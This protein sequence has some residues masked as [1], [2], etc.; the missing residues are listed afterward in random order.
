MS[1][2]LSPRPAPWQHRG[3]TATGVGGAGLRYD[4]PQ[5]RWVL[6]AT[7]LGSGM[8]FLDGTVV[9]VALP[10]IGD[11]LD[12]DIAGLQWTI[13]AYTLTLASFILLGGS[14][15]DRWGRRRM[16]VLGTIGFAAASLL[17]GIAPNI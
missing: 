5:G 3:V 13:N 4:E 16:F 1:R 7:V 10:S 17:C 6:L 14:A 11:S 2:S 15:G 8:A 12:T 9:N